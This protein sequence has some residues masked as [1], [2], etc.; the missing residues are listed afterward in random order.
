MFV[1][2]FNSTQYFQVICFYLVS[3]CFLNNARKSCTPFMEILFPRDKFLQEKIL[4]RNPLPR[5]TPI[6]TRK[7]PPESVCTLH[8]EH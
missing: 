7:S 8:N 3:H 6:P 5:P 1:L 4:L 2:R